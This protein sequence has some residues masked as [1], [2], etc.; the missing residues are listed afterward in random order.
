M[1]CGQEGVRRQ[2]GRVQ[3][4]EERVLGSRR[5]ESNHDQDLEVAS[6]A[7]AL[8]KCRPADLVEEN[9]ASNAQKP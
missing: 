4:Q 1:A 7:F 5:E 6:E 9:L 2:I 8:L 3:E